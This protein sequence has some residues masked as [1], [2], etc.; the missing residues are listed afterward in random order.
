MYM[1]LYVG[2]AAF[3]ILKFTVEIIMLLDLGKQSLH[4]RAC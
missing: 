1:T 4:R 2:L 3:F